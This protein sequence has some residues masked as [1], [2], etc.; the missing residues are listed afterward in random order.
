MNYIEFDVDG[1]GHFKVKESLSIIE[2]MQL[3]NRIDDILDGKY[4]ELRARAENISSKSEAIA[5]QIYTQLFIVQIIASLEML[6]VEKPDTIKSI[7]DLT[8]Y[9]TLLKIWEAYKKKVT[10][11]ED[12]KKS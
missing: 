5:E 4:Y 9:E 10:P 11:V 6:I 2:E 12:E 3:D 8:A 7:R 1:I